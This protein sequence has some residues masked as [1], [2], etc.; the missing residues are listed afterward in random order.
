MRQEV[1]SLCLIFHQRWFVKGHSAD[2]EAIHSDTERHINKD[3][4]CTVEKQ[5][6][7]LETPLRRHAFQ[8]EW[9][10]RLNVRTLHNFCK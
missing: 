3:S 10:I 5:N 9:I 4:C 7:Y 1:F 6:Y 8:K 2:L